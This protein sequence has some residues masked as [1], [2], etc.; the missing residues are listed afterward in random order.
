MF[1]FELRKDLGFW[2]FFF[3]NS[4]VYL[5]YNIEIKWN[6][7]KFFLLEMVKKLKFI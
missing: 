7:S 2:K 3:F 5:Y 1:V 6:S 4:N